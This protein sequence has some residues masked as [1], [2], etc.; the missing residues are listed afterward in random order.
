[1]IALNL[2]CTAQRH[3]RQVLD[4][5]PAKSK[6]PTPIL[7]WI[8][9]GAWQDLDKQVGAEAVKEFNDNGVSIVR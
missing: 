4:F 6:N 5:Y 8:H 9:G 3:E 2:P 1:L 7:F